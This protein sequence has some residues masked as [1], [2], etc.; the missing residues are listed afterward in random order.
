MFSI[1]IEQD[2][3]VVSVQELIPILEAAIVNPAYRNTVSS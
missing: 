3:D 2:S 1:T